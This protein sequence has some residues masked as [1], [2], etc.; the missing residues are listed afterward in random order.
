MMGKV[1]TLVTTLIMVA[2]VFTGLTTFLGGLQS[3]YGFA[4]S[5]KYQNTYDALNVTILDEDGLNYS[6]MGK[7]SENFQEGAR[8]YS[9]FDT[10][11][12]NIA[13]TFSIISNTGDVAVNMVEEGGESL[14]MPDWVMNAIGALIATLLILLIAGYITNRNL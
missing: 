7:Q 3:E 14:G 1:S 9:F 10:I 11:W 4:V 13:G 2:L 8:W 5:D 6:E 12:K